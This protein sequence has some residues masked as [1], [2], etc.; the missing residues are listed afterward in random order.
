MLDELMEKIQTEINAP[1]EGQIVEVLVE[2]FSEKKQNWRGRT[3]QNKLVF[4]PDSENRK[5]QLVNVKVTW[6][7]PYSM[8]GEFVEVVA[9]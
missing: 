7:G 8:V 1:L 9:G 3:P 5:G 4:F 2:E 6:A